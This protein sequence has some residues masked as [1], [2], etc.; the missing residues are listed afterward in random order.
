MAF[1]ASGA[2]SLVCG[3]PCSTARSP[4][5]NPL[6]SIAPA[7]GPGFSSS[8]ER[9]RCR[10]RDRSSTTAAKPSGSHRLGAGSDA[11]RS[12]TSSGASHR[13]SPPA[14]RG[15]CRPAEP[16]GCRR[17]HPGVGSRFS[18]IA[19]AWP[20][21]LRHWGPRASDEQPAAVRMSGR[22]RGRWR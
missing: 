6:N 18:G 21:A 5:C 8:V 1:V 9:T 20:E 7:G 13:S 22:A 4:L 3:T 19:N 2:G 12:S 14:R 17:V 10:S 11:T 16:G 15:H